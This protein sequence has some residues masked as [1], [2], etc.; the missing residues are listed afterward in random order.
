MKVNMKTVS[1]EHVQMCLDVVNK[2]IALEKSRIE[3]REQDERDE[4]KRKKE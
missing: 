4:A 3:K 2:R 1:F